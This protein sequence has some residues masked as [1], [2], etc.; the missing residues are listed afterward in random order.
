[1]LAGMPGWALQVVKHLNDASVDTAQVWKPTG[2]PYFC[3]SEPDPD[4]GA[5]G[6]FGFTTADKLAASFKGEQ[7]FQGQDVSKFLVKH[8]EME[9][10]AVEY[11]AKNIGETDTELLFAPVMFKLTIGLGQPNARVIAFVFDKFEPVSA[12]SPDVFRWHEESGLATTQAAQ[13][14]LSACGTTLPYTSTNVIPNAATIYGTSPFTPFGSSPLATDFYWDLQHEPYLTAAA[15]AA[16]R[17]EEEDGSPPAAPPA[18]NK[19]PPLAPLNSNERRR[20]TRGSTEMAA[21]SAVSPHAVT[22]RSNSTAPPAVISTA[23]GENI[24]RKLKT[25]KY[26]YCSDKPQKTKT[27]KLTPL[28]CTSAMSQPR[29]C[30]GSVGCKASWVINPF[31]TASFGGQA[32]WDYNAWNPSQIVVQGCLNAKVAV[33]IPKCNWCPKL[34]QAAFKACFSGRTIHCGN[35]DL[36]LFAELIFAA[37]LSVSVL[38]LH[39]KLTLKI[40]R[41]PLADD[42]WCPTKRANY[43]NGA[44]HPLTLQGSIKACVLWCFDIYNGHF[45]PQ[46]SDDA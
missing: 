33:G 21:S 37:T 32:T 18:P 1:M 39:G 43:L 27:K 31:V 42:E 10:M 3:R 34:A 35:A 2:E 38:V 45:V 46:Y 16:R 30:A 24:R 29:G 9:H 8:K 13:F 36:G 4:S 5:L 15:W 22:D 44:N 41:Y 14:N 11:L 7:R 25:K 12:I 23:L 20:L 19:P 28:P 26:T 17:Q 40:F 6:P